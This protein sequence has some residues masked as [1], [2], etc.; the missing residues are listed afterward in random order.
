MSEDQAPVQQELTPDQQ[1]PASE[2][3]PVQPPI[4]LDD[5]VEKKRFTGAMQAL[6]EKDEALKA[7]QAKLQE[8]ASEVE[9]FQKD[10]AV[11]EAEVGVTLSQ[12][13]KMLEEASQ[14]AKELEQQNLALQAN[15]LK[16]QVANEIG[17]PELVKIL[18]TIPNMAD[19]D[20]LTTVM[21]QIAGFANEQVQQREQQLLAGTT[22][23]TSPV[24]QG[25]TY[26]NAGDDKGWESYLASLEPYSKEYNQALEA[27]GAQ[28]HKR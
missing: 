17:H 20:S 25:P 13:D 10:L 21:T 1:A 5:Y 7:A 6:Q 22:P 28:I 3:A 16:V 26:P 14:K 24:Q 18:D 15:M 23:G 12:R 2:A 11:K 27:W 4:N 9:R 19:K 8:K